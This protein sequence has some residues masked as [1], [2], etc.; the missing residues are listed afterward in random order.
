[1]IAVVALLPASADARKP[2]RCAVQNLA[3]HAGTQSKLQLGCTVAGHVYRRRASLIGTPRH[4][5]VELS[6]GRY[7]AR[8]LPAGGF[9]GTD[10]FHFMVRVHHRPH[11][12][13]VRV[14]VGAPAQSPLPAAI[15]VPSGLTPPV[16]TDPALKPGFSPEISDYTTTCADHS[17]RLTTGTVTRDI[18][19]EENQGFNFTLEVGA[20]EREYHVRCLPGD[21]PSWTASRTGSPQA[22]WYAIANV[23]GPGYAMVFNTD[24]VPVWWMATGAR[25][26]DLKLIGDHTIAWAHFTPVDQD[27]NH[28][29]HDLSGNP[30]AID[31][32]SALT[33]SHDLQPAGNGNYYV[34]RYV[35]RDH[36]DLSAYGG[37]ADAS[38][39]DGEI[40]EVDPSGSI[41]WTW[42]SRDHIGLDESARWLTEALIQ[43]N[44]A[45]Y[46]IVHM[47]SV[48]VVGD[49]LIFSARHLDA[50]YEIDR[51]S[52]AIDWKL[53]GSPTPE[54]LDPIDDPLS[55]MPF[56][57]QHDARLLADG[58]LTVHDN[59]TLLGR[60]PRAVRYELDTAAKTATLLEQVSDARVTNSPCCGSAR[61]LGGGNWVAS[62]GG[63]P[64]TTELRPDGSPVFTLALD[65]GGFSYRADPIEPGRLDA[66]A[67]RAGM[68]VQWPR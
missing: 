48:E 31:L 19:L 39:I 65:S 9:A 24:G 40:V 38:V 51:A 20:A 53:G 60:P 57:G 2:A 58:T 25:P 26:V 49:K 66:E 3:V 44:P 11:R 37:P 28:E 62:W 43:S 23:D 29:F 6:K 46:D 16:T 14:E 15:G 47:N 59:G 68:N 13:R 64:T 12:G 8:Y 61:R 18:P 41:A 33:D 63:N 42:R 30:L 32:S 56:G 54:R 7:F 35:P 5:R 52:G 27:A 10:S 45:S 1:M 50:V 4:G 36:I 67:L 22:Q 55:P 34:I 21:F 17:V